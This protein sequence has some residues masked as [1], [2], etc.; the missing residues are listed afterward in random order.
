MSERKMLPARRHCETF[1]IRHGGQ[2]AVFHVT[3]GHYDDCVSVGEIFISGAKAGS[4]VEAN[5]RD[6]AI[7]VSLALQHGVPI[8]TMA[9][10]ITREANGEPST[11]IGR[12]LDT[13]QRESDSA[14]G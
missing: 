13:L 5:V 11:V 4:D 14:H 3:L 8:Q 10:A 1:E 6:G 12:V 7:L 2:G 9:S